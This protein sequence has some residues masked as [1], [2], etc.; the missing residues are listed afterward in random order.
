MFPSWVVVVYIF[1]P[2]SWEVEPG[3]FLRSRLAWS[4]EQIPG[5]PGLYRETLSPKTKT[6]T[7]TNNKKDFSKQAK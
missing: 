6:K 7:K 1:N 5:Q 3:G 2:S 4:T